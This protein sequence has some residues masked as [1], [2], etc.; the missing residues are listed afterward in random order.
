MVAGSLMV[1]ATCLFC[2]PAV[3]TERVGRM[4]NGATSYRNHAIHT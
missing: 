1:R 4:V 3:H 2:P